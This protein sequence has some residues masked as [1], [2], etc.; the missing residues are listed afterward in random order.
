MRILVVEDNQPL[1]EAVVE[2]LRQESYAVD[3]AQDGREAEELVEVNAYDAIL[4]DRSIPPPSG[5]ELLRRWRQAGLETPVLMLTGHADL[6]DMVGGLDCGADDYLTKPF[7]FPEL[8]ARLRSLLRRRGR[9]LVAQLV[10][11]DVVMD[12]SAR[13]V[14]VAGREVS[15]RPKEFAILEYLLTKVDQVVSK[16]ELVE[17]VWDDSFDSLSNVVDVTLHRV[18]QKIDAGAAAPLLETL[19]GVGY[20][21][22]SARAR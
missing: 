7:R 11:G 6:E 22:R 5:L 3:L 14:E 9:T 17:H 20:R 12:R 15:L 13:T 19:K 21:L 4:L 10:A 18:R 2:A 16:T 1:A 8:S